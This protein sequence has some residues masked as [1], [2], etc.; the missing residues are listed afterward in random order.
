MT[1]DTVKKYTLYKLRF[2]IGYTFL[3]VVVLT[4]FTLA[5]IYAPGGITVQEQQSTLVSASLRPANLASVL[6]VDFPYHVLQKLSLYL[7][8]MSSFTI[9]LPSLLVGFIAA[10]ALTMLLGKR[11]TRTSSIIT[12]GIVV[13][14]AQFVTLVATGTPDIMTI[15]WPVLLLLITLYA[16]QGKSLHSAAIYTGSVVIALSIFTPFMLYIILAFALAA[17]A[18]PRTR[19]LLKKS[20]RTAV[21][22]GAGIILLACGLAAYATFRDAT[23]MKTLLYRSDSFSLDLQANV[24]Q[25]IAQL[26]DFGSTSTIETGLLAPVFGL[27]ILIF[28]V[29]GAI[30]LYK[31]SFSVLSYI[32]AIW[33]AFLVPIILFNPSKVHL[34]TIPFALLVACGVSAVLNYWYGLFPENPYARV[35]ALVPVTILFACIIISGA[36]RYF[37]SYHY[38]APL[39][40]SSSHDLRLVAQEIASSPNI[41]LVVSEHEKPF[42]QLFLDASHNSTTQLSI[43][44]GSVVVHGAV[45]RDAVATRESNL[46]QS[47]SIRPTRVI[48]TSE[49]TSPSDRLYIYKKTTK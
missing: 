25:I 47:A 12:A 41:T 15:L 19:Y 16:T 37:Y 36:A 39:A 8:G 33:I 24:G 1:K 48:A 22:T 49:L 29:I 7:F 3:A 27:S 40:N 17:A 34:L 20:S 6:V 21:S 26:F 14:S 31:S 4:V 2:W 11:F 32:I 38:Y 45:N 9:K 13:V 23:F 5:A 18:H 43:D 10:V 30:Y 42:Y 28:V 46:V 35:F 44:T